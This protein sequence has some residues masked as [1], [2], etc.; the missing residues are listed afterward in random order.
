MR[1]YLPHISFFV[2]TVLLLLFSFHFHK[3]AFPELSPNF[4]LKKNDVPA[5]AQEFAQ[6]LNLSPKAYQSVVSFNEDVYAK[7]FL[8]L[9]YGLERLK[10]EIN[11]GV[12]IWDWSVRYFLPGQKEEFRVHLNTEGQLVKFVHIIPEKT[13]RPKL[14]REEALLLAQNFITRHVTN[15][16]LEKLKLTETGEQEKTGHHIYRFTWERTDW[17]WDDGKYHLHVAI[18]GDRVGKF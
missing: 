11:N 5:K 16:P 4:L 17:E 18:K 8:E 3:S 2:I 14:S 13:E 6:A 10:Q 15:H 7:Y 12:N 1:K 9:L